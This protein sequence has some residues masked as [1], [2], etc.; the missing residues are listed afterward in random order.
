MMRRDAD[1]PIGTGADRRT[2]V[3]AWIARHSGA[4]GL[5]DIPPRAAHDC[6][7]TEW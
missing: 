6:G 2:F 3:R 1:H 5:H 7:R 4:C